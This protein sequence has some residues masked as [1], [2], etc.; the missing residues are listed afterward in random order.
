M[1]APKCLLLIAIF[2]AAPTL[3]NANADRAAAREN[4]KQADGN[5]DGKLSKSEF[6]RFIDK[7]AKDGVGRAGMVRRLGAYDKAFSRVDSNKD[8]FVT[9]TELVAMQKK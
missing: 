6:R 9:G 8:G 2:V 5:N 3:A 1:D 4:F 7:N